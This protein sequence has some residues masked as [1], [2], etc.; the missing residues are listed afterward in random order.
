MMHDSTCATPENNFKH[1]DYNA[2]ACK[3]FEP[4]E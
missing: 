3:Y 4:E 1:I 2:T